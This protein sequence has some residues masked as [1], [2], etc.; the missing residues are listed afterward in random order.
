MK[1][2]KIIKHS[3]ITYIPDGT[4]Y[5]DMDIK[6]IAE[7]DI[8]IVNEFGDFFFISSLQGSEKENKTIT[9]EI[10]EEDEV[11]TDGESG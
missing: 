7:E 3:E 4:V 6:D 2:I 11:V 8:R 10:I 9:W 1:K 5:G